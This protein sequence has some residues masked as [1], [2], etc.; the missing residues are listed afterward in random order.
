VHVGAALRVRDLVGALER[1]VDALDDLLGLLLDL[2]LIGWLF[3]CYSGW[4]VGVRLLV[5]GGGGVF[6]LGLAEGGSVVCQTLNPLNTPQNITPSP[7]STPPP[8]KNTQH[9]LHHPS[10]SRTLG[11]ESAG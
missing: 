3:G 8:K 10:I 1:V 7:S 5:R 6:A 2:L 11:T 9:P 4:V